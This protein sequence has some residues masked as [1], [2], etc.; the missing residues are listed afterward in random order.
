MVSLPCVEGPNP[1]PLEKWHSTTI[2]IHMQT[3]YKWTLHIFK[4]KISFLIYFIDLLKD[5][6]LL[7]FLICRLNRLISLALVGSQSRKTTTVN[8]KQ[9][10]S[11]SICFPK[12]LWQFTGDKEM[13][14]RET[15]SPASWWE[16]KKKFYIYFSNIQG[17]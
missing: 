8:F 16:L 9:W 11:Y 7:P 13:K 14:S 17:L 12:K 4:L 10:R 15:G 3:L 5:C 2:G 1:N 6:L